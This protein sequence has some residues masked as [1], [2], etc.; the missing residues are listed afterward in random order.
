MT[1]KAED[2]GEPVAY[3][4]LKEGVPVYAPSGDRIGTVEH[5]LS[6]EPADVFHGLLIS[7]PDGRRFASGDQVAGLYEHGAVL[8][9]PAEQLARSGADLPGERSGGTLKRA[10]DWLVQPH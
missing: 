9:E 2:L 4:V 10:W 5:V 3:L 7:T 1:E 8:T 6:D